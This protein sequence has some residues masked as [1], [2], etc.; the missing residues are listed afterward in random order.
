MANLVDPPLSAV[1]FGKGV[2]L[3]P[4][5]KPSVK[6][7]S[8]RTTDCHRFATWNGPELGMGAWW[9]FAGKGSRIVG[10]SHVCLDHGPGCALPNV[11]C[12]SGSKTADAVVLYL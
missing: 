9:H 5:E 7:G 12:S 1:M 10:N 6:L 4:W 11:T 8:T 3:S 2:M